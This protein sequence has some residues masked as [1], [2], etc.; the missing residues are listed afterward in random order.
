MD[1]IEDGLKNKVQYHE[2]EGRAMPQNVLIS[3]P[4]RSSLGGGV[5]GEGMHGVTMVW[6]RETG[7][8]STGRVE[9]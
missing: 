7:K 2:V 6:P 3:F 5:G 9:L 8:V 1:D 4:K